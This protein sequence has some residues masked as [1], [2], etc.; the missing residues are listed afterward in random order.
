MFAVP[1]MTGNH[2]LLF[3]L[4]LVIGSVVQ[5]LTFIIIMKPVNPN[6]M[7]EF[8]EKEEEEIDFKDLKIS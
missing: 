3:I 8:E 6:E 2:G 5:A 1:T 7:V 4:A